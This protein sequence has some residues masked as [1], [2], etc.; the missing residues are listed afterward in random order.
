MFRG[1]AKATGDIF[2]YRPVTRYVTSDVTRSYLHNGFIFL[3]LLA[4]KQLL[5]VF[6]GQKSNLS[7]LGAVDDAMHYCPWSSGLV[8]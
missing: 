2:D 8:R 7:L 3:H 5:H 6:Y 1:N 4:I